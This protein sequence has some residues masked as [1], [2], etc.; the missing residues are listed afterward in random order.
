[1]APSTS[2]RISNEIAPYTFSS[3]F[4]S[5]EHYD[6]RLLKTNQRFIKVIY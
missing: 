1:M 4:D 6:L 5:K 3:I 2:R